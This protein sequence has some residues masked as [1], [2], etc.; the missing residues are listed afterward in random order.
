MLGLKA[1]ALQNGLVNGGAYDCYLQKLVTCGVNREHAYF[2]VSLELLRAMADV[3]DIRTVL[4]RLSDLVKQLLPHDAV[5]VVFRDERGHTVV[6]ASTGDFPAMTPQ[7]LQL[8][9]VDDVIIRDLAREALPVPSGVRLSQRL[10]ASGYRSMVGVSAWADSQILAVAFWSKQPDAF[11]PED[12]PLARRIAGHLALGVAHEQLA[13]EAGHAARDQARAERIEARVPMR[14]DDRR[15]T[16]HAAHRRRVRRVA[17]CAP[18][19]ER[20]SR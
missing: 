4:P 6:E 13:R 18:E 1:C 11:G 5:A 15:A 20:R 14:G 8:P 2:D 10:V 17:G 7:G 16:K 3:L 19:G 9:P 12:L